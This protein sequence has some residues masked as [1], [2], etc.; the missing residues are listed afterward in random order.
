M[1]I[2]ES[3]LASTTIT[4]VELRKKHV[5]AELLKFDMAKKERRDAIE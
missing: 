3:N 1:H 2:V 4:V 5:D